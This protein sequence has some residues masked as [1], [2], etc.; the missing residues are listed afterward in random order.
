MGSLIDSSVLIAVERGQLDLTRF[1]EQF[2]D[3][4]LALSAVTAS[5]LL[6][7]VHRAQDPAKR[8]TREAYV[9]AALLRFPIVAFDLGTARTHARVYAELSAKG[10]PI[11]AHDLLIGA[12]ALQLGWSIITRDQKSFSRISGLVVQMI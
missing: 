5:E 3:E 8:A 6:H 12:T 2:A 1:L 7:G 10:Q 4:E 9:E 11:G